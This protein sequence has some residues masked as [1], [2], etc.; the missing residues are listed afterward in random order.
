[1][2]LSMKNKLGSQIYFLVDKF[3]VRFIR[4]ENLAYQNIP[5]IMYTV[6]LNDNHQYNILHSI[7]RILQSRYF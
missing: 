5:F 1:M 6:I 3:N 2:Q 4:L 7:N